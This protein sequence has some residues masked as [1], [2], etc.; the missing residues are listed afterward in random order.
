MYISIYYCFAH[1]HLLLDS[2]NFHL[3][4]ICIK[5]CYTFF[6]CNFDTTLFYICLHVLFF[7][8]FVFLFFGTIQFYI[9]LQLH[10]HINILYINLSFTC[11]FSP[12][13]LCF[14]CNFDTTLFC[15]CLHVVVFGTIQFYI[16]FQLH[17]Y[18]NI[19]YINLSFSCYFGP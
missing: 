17:L 11:Y 19:L 1:S 2:T 16:I 18:I 15:I 9:I 3:T 10:L 8:F 14:I 12:K 4:N 13:L 7:C 5:D 6:T